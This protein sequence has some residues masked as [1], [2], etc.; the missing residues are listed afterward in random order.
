M[1]VAGFMNTLCIE[2]HKYDIRVNCLSPTANTAMTENLIPDQRIL[3]LMTPASVTAG[4]LALVCKEAP[5]RTILATGA[6]GYARTIVYET[7][8]IYLPPEDQ[9][10][11]NVLANMDKISDPTNKVELTGGWMQ[12][13]KFVSK[14]AQALGVDLTPKN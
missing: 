9:T 11:E 2:G 4:L 13:D 12:T 7:D 5:N 3:D 8:G 10:P 6:G 14:A 1:A